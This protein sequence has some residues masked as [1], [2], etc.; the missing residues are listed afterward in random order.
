MPLSLRFR[1][2]PR[3]RESAGLMLSLIVAMDRNRLIGADNGLPWRLPADLRNFRA[4]TLGKPIV[5][6]RRTHES[7]G[8]ALP[9]RLN[10]VVTRNPDFVPRDAVRV[11]HS[12]CEAL[13]QAGDAPEVV[14]IGGAELYRRVLP[15]CDRIYLTEVQGEFKGDT[16]FPE[17][18]RGEWREIERVEHPAADPDDVGCSFVIL[19]RKDSG[20]GAR[21]LKGR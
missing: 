17:W 2:P 16:W 6:G 1:V 21:G 20:T 14:V 7:L 9:G 12:L 18:D 8:R 13:A 3:G 11:A 4:M 19:E 5:M 15:I 10:I